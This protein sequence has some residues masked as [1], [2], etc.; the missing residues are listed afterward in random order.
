MNFI[1]IASTVNAIEIPEGA[2]NGDILKVMFPKHE[3][4][5]LIAK[6]NSCWWEMN[7]DGNDESLI[8][9]SEWWNAPY[10]RGI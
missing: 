7:I 9:Q 8:F 6:D 3:I 1:D 5:L 2:T 4:T 10:M